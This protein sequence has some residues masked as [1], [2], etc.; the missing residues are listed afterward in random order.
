MNG[1]VI[2]IVG[3]Y[4]H[5]ILDS[6]RQGHV[7]ID[8]VAILG[9]AKVDAASWSLG[10][11]GGAGSDQRASLPSETPDRISQYAVCG[12]R[13]HAPRRRFRNCCNEDQ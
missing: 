8:L 7:G 4:G 5:P 10:D 9:E 1:W 13:A 6:G 11:G 12:L 2:G 3:D